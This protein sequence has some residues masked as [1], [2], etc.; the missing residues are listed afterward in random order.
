[1]DGTNDKTRDS[2]TRETSDSPSV[3]DSCARNLDEEHKNE[4]YEEYIDPPSIKKDNIDSQ[5]HEEISKRILL[6]KIIKGNRFGYV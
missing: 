5:S 6:K 3:N 1:M 2:H 4:E